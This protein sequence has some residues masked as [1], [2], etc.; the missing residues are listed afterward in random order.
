VSL[1][2]FVVLRAGCSRLVPWMDIV[3][4]DFEMDR[5]LY[6]GVDVGLVVASAPHMDDVW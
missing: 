6:C 4:V 1:D 2:L 3:W 5:G